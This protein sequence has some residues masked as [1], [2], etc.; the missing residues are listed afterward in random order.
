MVE[1]QNCV[2]LYDAT[3]YGNQILTTIPKW[4]LKEERESNGK[5]VSDWIAH[6]S[7]KSWI[8]SDLLLRLTGIIKEECPHFDWDRQIRGIVH[9]DL[10][11]ELYEGWPNK[12]DSIF[13]QIKFNQKI[14]RD[15]EYQEYFEEELTKTRKLYNI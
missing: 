5:P 12:S 3:I 11:S 2:Y 6:L 10:I 15:P 13:D 4:R 14:R 1:D 8:T 7:S 9:R